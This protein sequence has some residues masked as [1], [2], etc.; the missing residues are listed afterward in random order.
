M[1]KQ[2][3]LFAGLQEMRVVLEQDD[4]ESRELQVKS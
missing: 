2:V 1:M 4:A 3:Q